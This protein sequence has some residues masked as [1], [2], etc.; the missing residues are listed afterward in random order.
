MEKADGVSM[1]RKFNLVEDPWIRLQFHEPVGLRGFFEADDGVRL[2]GTPADKFVAFRLLLAVAQAAVPFEELADHDALEDLET[3]DLRDMA[4]EYLQR[5]QAEFELYDPE[6]PFLQYPQVKVTKK[7]KEL[8]T[9]GMVFGTCIGNATC[10]FQTNKMGRS[11]TP[12]EETY[13]LLGQLLLGFSGK[14][15]D[16]AV[17]LDGKMDK[18]KSAPSVPSLGRG[19]LHSYPLGSNIFET[20][21]LNLLTAE[22]LKECGGL[23]SGMG[24]PAWEK[25]PKDESCDEAKAYASSYMGRLMPLARF[26]HLDNGIIHL[27]SGIAYPA[28]KDT[29]VADPS[30]STS[31]SVGKSKKT[32]FSALYARTEVQPWRQIESVL[33]FLEEKKAGCPLIKWRNEF[34]D[35]K[36]IWCLGLKL[37][38]QAGEQYFS[39]T[40]DFVEQVFQLEPGIEKS[41]FL[42]RY[43]SGMETLDKMRK[44]AYACVIGY[45]KEL[46]AEGKKAAEKA[47]KDFCRL[48]D[49]SGIAF[50]DAC[51]HGGTGSLLQRFAKNVEAAYAENCSRVGARNLIAYE[52]CR[53]RIGKFLK[54]NS[55]A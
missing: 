36:G 18:K 24:R 14:K 28:F 6:R 53:P 52:K 54:G 35:F 17:S 31:M 42:N 26:C 48:C 25:M 27:T 10:H 20:L 33:G 39:G 19:Y 47:S 9:N 2:G 50:V 44:M 16:A 15:P 22:D 38:E 40:D 21:K 46:S 32:E 7:D 3:E 41:G 8:P 12:A 13:V 43:K 23:S 29:G 1:P 4:L 55:Q 11:L 5:H 51:A 49:A 30:V 37:S 34:D 45:Y